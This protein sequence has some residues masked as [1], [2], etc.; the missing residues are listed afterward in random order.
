MGHG[1][2]MCREQS[3]VGVF[4][5]AEN[6]LLRD[7]FVRLLASKNDL[8]VVGTGGL[9]QQTVFDVMSANPEVILCDSLAE[10][11]ADDG[12]IRQLRRTAPNLKVLMFGMDC[13]EEKFLIAVQHGVTGYILKD[14]SAAEVAAAIRAVACGDCICPPKLCTAL[15]N[16]VAGSSA[17]NPGAQVTKK[18]GLTRREQQLVHL[19]SLGLTNKEIA[20]RLYLSEQ[21]VKNH[22]RRM[23]R[24]S[25]AAGRLEAVEFW[26]AQG[27][28][29]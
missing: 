6:R 28:W 25:G 9:C 5:L 2:E 27:F 3:L 16:Y 26:R 7:V 12:I 11:V 8:Q 22:L 14:A 17:W 29:T 15:F 24:K 10:A 4:L 23:F 20:G 13:E 1:I 21:T 18:I 19:I